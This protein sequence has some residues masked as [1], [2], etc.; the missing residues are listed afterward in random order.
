MELTPMAKTLPVSTESA[1]R[2][3]V[4]MDLP[5]VTY[6]DIGRVISAGAILENQVSELLFEL[7]KIDYPE[8]RVAF[9]GSGLVSQALGRPRGLVGRRW[10]TIDC[11]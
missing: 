4:V 11:V 5:P 2:Y 3:Q 8:G 1:T 9:R 7:M 10:T 6:E